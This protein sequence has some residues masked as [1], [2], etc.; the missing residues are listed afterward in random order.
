MEDGGGTFMTLPLTLSHLFLVGRKEPL[1]NS[2]NTN[3]GFTGSQMPCRTV[4]DT[5][6][7]CGLVTVTT[8]HKSDLPTLGFATAFHIL[9]GS[10]PYQQLLALKVAVEPAVSF[11]RLLANFPELAGVF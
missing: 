10:H 11:T 4:K 5:G 2:R 1:I 9:C 6:S 3:A 8:G 7:R